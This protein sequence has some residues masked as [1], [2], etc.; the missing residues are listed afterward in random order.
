MIVGLTGGTGFL[1]SHVLDQLLCAGHQVRALTRRDQSPRAGVTWVVGSLEQPGALIALATGT[2]VVVHVAGVVNA[3]NAD[4]FDAGN[5]QGTMQMLAAATAVDVKR[6]VHISSIAAREPQL[7]TYCASKR[8]AEDAV[9]GSALVW[10][11][12]RPPAIYGPRDT[13]N[14][15]LFR[16]ARR[17]AIP[18]PVNG[19]VSVIHA[20]DLA[21]LIVA[22]AERAPGDALYEVDDGHPGGWSH[23]EYARMIGKAVGRRPFTPVLPRTLLNAAARIDGAVRGDKAKL[24]RDRVAYIV[25]PDW[26]S[27]PAKRPPIELWTPEI[28]TPDGL[29]ATAAWYRAE[30]WL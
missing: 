28:A 14:L 27:D 18:L 25:H 3:P 23:R 13:D 1:G 17:G 20:D 2:E 19:R 8:A 24:T 12:V 5:R 30:G 9:A 22:M 21:R 16:L 11:I 15:E 10:S 6:F 26:V 7:S 4:A 29:A